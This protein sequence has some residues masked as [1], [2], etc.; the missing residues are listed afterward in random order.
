MTL[1]AN[2]K[3]YIQGQE[4]QRPKEDLQVQMVQDV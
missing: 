4:K 1:S 2:P 3:I